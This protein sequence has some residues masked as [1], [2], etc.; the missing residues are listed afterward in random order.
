MSSDNAERTLAKIEGDLREA[1]E[2]FMEADT[3]LK[4]AEDDRSAA[5]DKINKCQLEI[6]TALAEMRQRSVAGSKWSIAKAKADGDPVLQADDIADDQ[7][8][9]DASNLSSSETADTVLSHIENLRSYTQSQ[10]S[11][12]VVKIATSK[13]RTSGSKPS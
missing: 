7:P 9:S 12:P 1:E 8:D 11:D 2:A 5:L 6:D 10:D 4:I 3:R 13:R